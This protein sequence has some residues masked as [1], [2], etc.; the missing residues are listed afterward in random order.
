MGKIMACSIGTGTLR[1]IRA[2]INPVRSSGRT[3]VGRKTPA[4]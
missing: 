3:K 4:R 1:M 2:T